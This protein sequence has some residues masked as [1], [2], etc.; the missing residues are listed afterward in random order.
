MIQHLEDD[1]RVLIFAPIGRDAAL[2][3]DLLARA[4]IA[5][6][7]C[8]NMTALA[9]ELEQG[10]GA[11]VLTEEALDDAQLPR[12]STALG[13]KPAPVLRSL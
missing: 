1:L 2:T 9:E 7:V 12:L 13:Q 3:R 11:I 6:D 10:A 5:G 8:P 4:S